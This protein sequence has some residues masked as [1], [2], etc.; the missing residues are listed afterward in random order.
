MKTKEFKI[1]SKIVWILVIGNSLLTL[2]GIFAK[3]LHWSYSENWFTIGLILFFSSW[4]IILSDIYKNK[5]YNRSFWIL[6]MFILPTISPLV[7]MIQRNKLIRLGEGFNLN[8]N[9]L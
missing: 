4:I 7:Y 2:I 3:T 9:K 8:K 1:S 6:S 5:I